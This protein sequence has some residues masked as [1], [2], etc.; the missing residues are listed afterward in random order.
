MGE[1][2]SARASN[3]L[4]SFYAPVAVL[5]RPVHLVKPSRG[6]ETYRDRELHIVNLDEYWYQSSF[7]SCQRMSVLLDEP[8]RIEIQ[9][10]NTKFLLLIRPSDRFS[11]KPKHSNPSGRFLP[12]T[13]CG[14]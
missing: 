11:Q 9:V 10:L 14:D 7:P 8:S 5:V 4:L 3:A 13:R 2:F 1:G 12:R 6:G